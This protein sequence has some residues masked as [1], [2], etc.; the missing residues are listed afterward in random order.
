[1][2]RENGRKHKNRQCE[3]LAKSDERIL[4]AG[5]EALTQFPAVLAN[6]NQNLAWT[7]ELG[8]A[9]VNQQQD[10]NQA[11]QTMRQRAQQAGNLRTTPQQTMNTNGSRFCVGLSSI[12]FFYGYDPAE[13]SPY[14]Q[15][16]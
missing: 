3:K 7:S 16:G 13:C 4:G 14:D 15:R 5:A 8:N 10:L 1:L 9:W 11:S 6:V 2:K 12:I